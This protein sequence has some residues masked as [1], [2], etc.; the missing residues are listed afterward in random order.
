MSLI[1]NP[2]MNQQM[3]MQIMNLINSDPMMDQQ[4][5]NSMLNN[6]QGAFSKSPAESESPVRNKRDSLQPSSD[7]EEVS[8]MMMN[9]MNRMMMNNTIMNNQMMNNINNQMLNQM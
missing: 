8:N 4:M 5:L 9:D 3:L 7:T 2:M 6:M 1:N